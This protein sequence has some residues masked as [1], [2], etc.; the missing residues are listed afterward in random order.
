MKQGIREFVL[1]AGPKVMAGVLFIAINAL[2]LRFLGPREFGIYSLCTAIIFLADGVLGAAFDMG[3]LR[4]APLHQ[5]QEP[6]RALAIERVALALKL[7]LIFI[8]ISVLS[9]FST[10]ISEGLFHQE[11]LE[12][13]IY[14]TCLGAAGSLLL[15]SVLTHVQL[16]RRFS[17]YGMLDLSQSL[18][19]IGFVVIVLIWFKPTPAALLGA[20]A[21]GPLLVFLWGVW[22][23]GVLPLGGRLGYR[24]AFGEFVPVVKWF[25]VTFSF[26]AMLSRADIFLLAWFSDIEQVG[27]FSGAMVFAMIP[28]LLGSY[29]A[30]VLGPRIM[31]HFRDGRFPH[32]Y[33]RVQV[34]CLA[35]ALIIYLLAFVGLDLVAPYVFPGS[36]AASASVLL[37]LL[38]G[39]LAA[40]TAFPLAIPFVMFVRPK[41]IFALDLASAPLLVALYFFAIQEYGALG[42]AWVASLSRVIK[43]GLVQLMAWKWSGG[44]Y[45]APT[46]VDETQSGAHRVGQ[47]QPMNDN[48]QRTSAVAVASPRNT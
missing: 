45:P 8:A 5:A 33:K 12:H 41:F 20:V 19:K 7:S 32:L 39:T 28:E 31:P 46:P 37:I 22:R 27:I 2:L 9:A 43:L 23:E 38:P 25:L 40:M 34:V 21:A 18:L 35:A 47:E 14:L 29:L 4:L 10:E 26:S 16:T 13:L 1:V 24:E 17:A 42:A 15:R 44:K 36:F 48:P 6:G 11:D 3:V 30:V